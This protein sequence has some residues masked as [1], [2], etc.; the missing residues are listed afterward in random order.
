[1]DSTYHDFSPS[2]TF[3]LE[4]GRKFLLVYNA[5]CTILNFRKTCNSHS[6]TNLVRR[7]SFL[8]YIQ[9]LEMSPYFTQWFPI[10]HCFLLGDS[11]ILAHN[12]VLCWISGIYATHIHKWTWGDDWMF[13]ISPSSGIEFVFHS[14]SHLLPSF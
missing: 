8:Q 11:F 1:M 2:I 12:V 5:E 6:T 9:L 3:F 4:F 7:L 10:S 14:I 13:E